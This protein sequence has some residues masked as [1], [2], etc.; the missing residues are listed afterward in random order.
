[1]ASD[2]P[3]LRQWRRAARR[4]EPWRAYAAGF[5]S[6]AREPILLGLILFEH[7]L[8]KSLMA[9]EPLAGALRLTWRR[10]AVARL[11]EAGARGSPGAA[12]PP[13]LAALAPFIAATPMAGTALIALVDVYQDLLAPEALA[14]RDRF[15][16]AAAALARAR[17]DLAALARSEGKGERSARSARKRLADANAKAGREL[18]IFARRPRAGCEPIAEAEMLARERVLR[19]TGAR[20]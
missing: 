9:A 15:F 14:D 11:T 13:D 7:E 20:L 12:G 1:M 4:I 5:A 3:F 2:P 17:L 16:A 8:R 19:A 18:L 6:A 10:E